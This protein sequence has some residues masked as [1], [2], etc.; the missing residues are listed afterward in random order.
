MTK[1]QED[2]NIGIDK[3]KELLILLFIGFNTNQ[4]YDN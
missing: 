3:T 4:I 2:S 1:V